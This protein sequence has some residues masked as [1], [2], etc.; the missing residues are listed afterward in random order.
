MGVMRKYLGVKDIAKLTVRGR[1]A[2]GPNL[3]LQISEWGTKSWLF[4]FRIRG[5]ARHMGLGPV[6][7][8]TLAEARDKAHELRRQVLNGVDPLEAKRT[9]ERA[10]VLAEAKQRTFKETALAYIAA[11]EAGWKGDKSRQQW[12]LSLEKHA[13]PKL[14]ALMVNEIDTPT[15]IA[16][17]EP[18]WKTVPETARRVRNRIELILDYA[19][20][21]GLRT[22]DNPARWSGLLEN[23]LPKINGKTHFAALPYREVGT[24]MAA[25]RAQQGMAARALEFAILTATR[26]NE[27]CGARWDEIDGN[28]W[29]IPA[30][31]MKGGREHRVP[32][33]K[34][35]NKLLAALPRNGEHLFSGPSGE[36]ALQPRRLAFFLNSV[37]KRTDTT[38]HGFRATF[39]TWASEMTA[40]PNFVVEMALAH[41]IPSAV[42]AAYQRGDL[43]EKRRRLMEDWAKYCGTPVA[44]A[45]S[46]EV[47]AIRQSMK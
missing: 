27:T 14:G 34:Q 16:V 21:K 15:V 39:K 35:A 44:R 6:D 22:G 7:L 8:V 31:R 37:M 26:A 2:C 43:I 30:V 38:V 24:F 10:L 28:V 45:T 18:I 32:L 11:H 9:T 23:L 46:C 1:Y 3:Y 33:S 40:Y 36:E 20:A 19:S 4:R 25:L 5:R 17:V 29:I 42:E 12:T 41:A 47:V 13:F